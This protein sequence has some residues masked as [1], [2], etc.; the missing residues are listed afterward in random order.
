MLLQHND[1]N[2]ISKSTQQQKKKKKGLPPTI[3]RGLILVVQPTDYNDE[4]A[5]PGPAVNVWT[6]LQQ[7][8]AAAAVEGFSVVCLS[9]QSRH[10]PTPWVLRDFVPPVLSWTLRATATPSTS[11]SRQRRQQQPAAVVVW[12]CATTKPDTDNDTA[13]RWHVYSMNSSI[14]MDCGSSCPTCY[15]ASCREAPTPQR[16]RHL[17][18]EYEIS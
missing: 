12:H 1:D 11:S 2:D 17:V 15:L 16:L 18:R 13:S 5:P 3:L 6:A 8:V 14:P 9:P 7:L 10:P 4:Y